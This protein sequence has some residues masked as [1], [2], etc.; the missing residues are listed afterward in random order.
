MGHNLYFGVALSPY[1]V[2]FCNALHDRFGFEIFH[3]RYPYD[4]DC[5][6]LED[7]RKRSRFENTILQS[8]KVGGRFIIKGLKRILLENDPGIVIVPEFS[9]LTLQIIS[10]RRSLKKNFK[11]VV[12]CDDCMKMIEGGDYSAF[13]KMMRHIVPPRVDNLIL[14]ND[15][16]TSWYRSHYGKGAFCPILYDESDFRE[17][18]EMALPRAFEIRQEMGLEGKKVVVFVGRLIEL[19]R[20]PLLMESFSKVRKDEELVIIGDGECREALER[21]RPPHCAFVGSKTGDEL[22]AWLNIADILV[23]PSR[24]EAFGAVVTEALTAGCPVVVS[25]AAGAVCMIKEG[26][27]GSVFSDENDLETK[28]SLWLGRV[29]P[30][31]A[32]SLREDLSPYR[33]ND[34]VESLME[35]IRR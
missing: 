18:L 19:K 8:R 34:T 27:N 21:E 11:I 13:H 31:G 1:R 32:F 17:R 7:I 29:E 24:I 10:L 26:E 33:F 28:L 23:L 16:V 9:L 12:S 15:K 20:I 2:D 25:N 3:M 22:L 5:F 4:S 14:V 6:D 30:R 35:E